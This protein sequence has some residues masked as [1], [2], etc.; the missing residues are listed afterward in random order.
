[1]LILLSFPDSVATRPQPAYRWS[2]TQIHLVWERV[3]RSGKSNSVSCTIDTIAYG[4]SYSS[5]YGCTSGATVSYGGRGLQL[6]E[7]V[8]LYMY[9]IL[10]VILTPIARRKPSNLSISAN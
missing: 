9:L 4:L 7:L 5:T 6:P 2:R 3:P 8:W 1:M 10:V